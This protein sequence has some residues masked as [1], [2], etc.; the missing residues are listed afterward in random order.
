VVSIFPIPASCLR[1]VS[2]ILA[3]ISE[4]WLTS[5]T[6]MIFEGTTYST[7]LAREH[8]IQFTETTLHYHFRNQDDEIWLSTIY[9]KNEVESKPSHVLRQIAKEIGNGSA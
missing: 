2:A 3:E 4:E 9:S 6:Y 8:A 1:L 7:N 5:R